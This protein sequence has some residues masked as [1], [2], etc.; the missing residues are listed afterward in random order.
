MKLDNGEREG[1]RNE[2]AVAPL[3]LN[4]TSFRDWDTIDHP[5]EVLQRKDQQHEHIL[6][7]TLLKQTKMCN[8][9]EVNGEDCEKVFG[10]G[11]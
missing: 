9:G 1:L 3:V 4:L 6:I 8:G 5:G 2:I 7:R 11:I 10:S